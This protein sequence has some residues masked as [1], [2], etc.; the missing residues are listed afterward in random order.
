MNMRNHAAVIGGSIAGLWTARVLADH[1]DRV[2]VIDR[3]H[4]PTRRK[5]EKARRRDG[6]CMCCWCAGSKFSTSFSPACEP[7]SPAKASR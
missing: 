7:N 4:F 1:F 3:D 5:R 2:T 6:R